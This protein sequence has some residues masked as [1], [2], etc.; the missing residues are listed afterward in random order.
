MNHLEII[1]GKIVPADRLS[2]LISLWRFQDET[3]VFTNGCFDI[4]HYGH[5]HLLSSAAD[6]GHKLIVGLNSD[7]SVK[8]LKGAGRPLNSQKERGSILAG[9]KMVN[10]VVVFEEDTPLELIKSVQPNVLVKGGDYKAA[11]VVGAEEIKAWGG[12]V[13]IVDFLEGYSSTG[14]AEKIKS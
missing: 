1:Q 8:R 9:L 3:V 12:R 7:D 2:N 14:V 11:E 6:F 10:A 5:I 13:E 4:L